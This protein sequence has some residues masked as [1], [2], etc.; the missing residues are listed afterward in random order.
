M[1]AYVVYRLSSFEI[2]PFTREAVGILRGVNTIRKG[3]NSFNY[4]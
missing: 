2:D 4:E 3:V 1:E